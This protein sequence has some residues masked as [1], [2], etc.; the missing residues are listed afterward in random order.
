MTPRGRKQ[1]LSDIREIADSLR[2]S[3]DVDVPDLTASI[4]NAVDAERPFLS[5]QTRRMVI[6]G[7]FALGLSIVGVVAFIAVAHRLSPSS[8]EFSPQPTPLSAVVETVQNEAQVKLADLQRQVRSVA[9][10]SD[11][12][13]SPSQVLYTLVLP[14]GGSGQAMAV[15][16]TTMVGPTQP[17]SEAVQRCCGQTAFELKCC[18]TRPLAGIAG[19][20]GVPLPVQSSWKALGA[21]TPG[22]EL[23]E[24]DPLAQDPFA[25]PR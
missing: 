21:G 5:R 9:A 25:L 24:L 20:K 12:S 3:R 13:S 14:G 11:E 7:R 8:L 17:P 15:G 22:R 18:A 10:L 16:L 4:L 6:A 23:D 1:R 2:Q 19:I